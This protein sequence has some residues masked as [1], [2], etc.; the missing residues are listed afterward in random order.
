MDVENE[1]LVNVTT[2]HFPEYLGT[3]QYKRHS[4]GFAGSITIYCA[5]VSSYV[6]KPGYLQQMFLKK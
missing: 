5:R 4:K 1:S 2:K 3:T 6:D